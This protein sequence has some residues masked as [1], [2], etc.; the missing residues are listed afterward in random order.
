MANKIKLSVQPDPRCPGVVTDDTHRDTHV[1]LV[2]ELKEFYE[3]KLASGTLKK[4]CIC[5]EFVRAGIYLAA[6]E[7]PK[8]ALV[9]WV[10]SIIDVA[11]SSLDE[12]MN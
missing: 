8:E 6:L 10:Q 11:Y 7:I 12:R 3:N 2:L 1:A 9:K 5:R 4:E